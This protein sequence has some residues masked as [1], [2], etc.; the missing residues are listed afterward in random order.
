MHR[1]KQTR[2]CALQ[3]LRPEFSKAIRK[4]ISAEEDVLV[5]YET[6]GAYIDFGAFFDS[7]KPAYSAQIISRKQLI[8]AFSDEYN[9]DTIRTIQIQLKDIISVEDRRED[10]GYWVTALGEGKTRLD[11]SFASQQMGEDF[12]GILQRSIEQEKNALPR[13]SSENIEERL[14]ALTKLHQNGLIDDLEFQQKRKELLD[15]L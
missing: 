1:P 12:A 11:C 9:R 7:E 4:Y 5:C 6:T 8:L 15:Q 3:D 10:K 14:Q 2:A 13:P